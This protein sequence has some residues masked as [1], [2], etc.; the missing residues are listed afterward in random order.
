MKAFTKGQDATFLTWL[1]KELLCNENN[2]WSTYVNGGNK[3]ILLK[4]TFT[5]TF[6]TSTLTGIISACSGEY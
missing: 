1:F 5:Y 2:A 4:W 3:R 6:P